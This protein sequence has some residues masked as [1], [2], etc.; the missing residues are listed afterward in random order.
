MKIAIVGYGAMGKEIENVCKKQNI[1]ISNI[2]DIDNPLDINKNYDFD[3]AI[4]FSTPSAVVDNVK[5]LAKQKKNIVIGTTNWSDKIGL[6][7]QIANDNNIGIVWASNFSIGMQIFFKLVQTSSQ[8]FNKFNEYDSFISEIHHTNKIDSPSGTALSI[9]NIMIDNINSKQKL[10]TENINRKISPDEL[11]ISSLRG[12]NICG[13]HNVYFDSEVDTIQLIHNAKN[14]NGFA[15][16]AV[17]AAKF[18]YNKSGFYN[19]EEI[20]F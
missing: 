12:G 10:L 13:Q 18:I 17:F 14:R 20:L 8:L 3:V 19:F 6:V 9:A 5:I 11:H 15:T 1:F 4:E 7:K 2:F 16:G